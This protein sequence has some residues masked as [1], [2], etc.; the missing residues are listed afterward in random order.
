MSA[1]EHIKAAIEILDLEGPSTAA[2][3]L[4]AAIDSLGFNEN[5]IN[6][7]NLYQDKTENLNNEVD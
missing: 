5:Y 7:G 3:F 2:C 1:V 4:Q 6:I